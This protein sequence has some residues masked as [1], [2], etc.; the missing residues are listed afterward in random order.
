MKKFFTIIIVGFFTA[1]SLFGQ[2]N[3]VPPYPTTSN[4]TAINVDLNFQ[5]DDA[6]TIY[7]VIFPYDTPP[8]D[9]VLIKDRHTL[10]PDESFNGGGSYSYT[11]GDVGSFV[12]QIAEN[13][14]TNTFH[15]IHIVSENEAG[16]ILGTTQKLTITTPSCPASIF[17]AT[18]LNNADRCV[19]G[20]GAIKTY[21][22]NTSE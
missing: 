8:M 13:L 5:L 21:T 9:P 12:T 22:F 11:L 19:N 16:T 20:D 4:L 7:W 10:P 15:S 1:F 18:A 3:W 6:G 2:P 14:F 17:V